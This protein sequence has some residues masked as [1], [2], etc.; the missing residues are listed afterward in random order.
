MRLPSGQDPNHPDRGPIDRA[1]LAQAFAA[2]DRNHETE[3]PATTVM[4]CPQT[5]QP[6]EQID[7][8]FIERSTRL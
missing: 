8:G 1:V 5:V 7:C 6:L 4:M 2:I 3:M